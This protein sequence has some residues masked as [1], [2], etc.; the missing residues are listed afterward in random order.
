MTACDR[1]GSG[2]EGGA[3]GGPGGPAGKADGATDAC[4][5]GQTCLDYRSYE[6][7][8][9]N[10]LC[11]NY[12][13]DAPLQTIDGG[14]VGAKPKNVYCT[15]ADS[16]AS[17]DRISSPQTRIL[18]W[19]EET[20]AGDEVFLAYLS[21]S[22]QKVADA[23]CSAIDRGAEVTFV[24]DKI[25]SKAEQVIACGGDVFTRGHQGSVG[26]AHN[27]VLMINPRAAGPADDDDAFMKLSFGSGNMSSGTHLHHENWHFLEVARSSYFVAAHL[28][29][30]ESLL[31]PAHSDGKGAYRAFM[32]ECRADIEATPET[33]MVP[34]FIPVLDDS[35]ALRDRMLAAID[36]AETIDVGAHRFSY[37]TMVDALAERL[38]DEDREFVLRL[39]ADDDLYWLDPEE[40]TESETVGLNTFVEVTKVRELRE[41][42]GGRGRF[43]D[44]YLETNHKA[45]LLHHNKFLVFSGLDSGPDAI[46]TGSSNLT[47]T[48][49]ET[50]LENMYF[51]SV[52]EVVAAY[53]NQFGLFWDGHGVL[54]PGMDAPPVATPRRAMP[55]VVEAPQEP[56]EP[57]ELPDEPDPAPGECGVRIIEVLYDAPS[58]D[59]GKEYVKLHN[60]CDDAVSLDA[61]SLGW[62]GGS[63]TRGSVDL[64]GSISAGACLVVGGPDAGLDVDF[65]PNLQ[66]SGVVADGVALFDMPQAAVDFTTVPTDAVIYGVLN[67]DGLM[68]PQGNRPEPHVGDADPGESL[69]RTA[70][71]WA[72]GT[73]SPASCP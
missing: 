39:V 47:G 19:L 24:L 22:D 2:A 36:E 23:L 4:A 5:Q 16:E 31:D 38:E 3:P 27:K 52:P 71:G 63:Y 45:H 40:P 55:I 28:C 70:A 56:S 34:Y 66:N 26:F 68:D 49:F 15:K 73:P 11:A 8:F 42:D 44:R 18:D 30:M 67:D 48:G 60:T 37:T 72:I 43:E 33:D 10:P 17:G 1:G 46:I 20:G 9:T 29:L 6:V 69:Q 51:I 12:G 59:G 41:A 62:G 14:S 64:S 57:I 7:L 65:S 21:F 25:S 54:P 61:M 53:R 50:N 32:N 58:S 35:R 13:Y